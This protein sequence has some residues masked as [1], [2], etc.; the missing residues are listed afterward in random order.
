[1]EEQR[2]RQN[3][4][5]EPGFFLGSLGRQNTFALVAKDVT[6]PFDVHGVLYIPLESAGHWR[7]L[8]VKELNAAGIRVDAN[9]AF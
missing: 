6:L 2:A 9:L 4:L 8:L 3:V 1:V 7:L 5:F